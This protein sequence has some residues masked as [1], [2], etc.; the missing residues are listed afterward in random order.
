MKNICK[1][2]SYYLSSKTNFAKCETV[3]GCYRDKW[4]NDESSRFTYYLSKI[5]SRVKYITFKGVKNKYMARRGNMFI[6]KCGILPSSSNK[7]NTITK[8]IN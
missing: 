2:E 7:K 1:I 8:I 5:E 3:K 4:S 6:A